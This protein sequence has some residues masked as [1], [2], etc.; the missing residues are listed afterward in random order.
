MTD[1]PV[2]PIDQSIYDSRSPRVTACGIRYGHGAATVLWIKA[3]DDGWYCCRTAH[4]EAY[5]N[6]LRT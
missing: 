3:G 2:Y 4:R 6:L 5:A 1:E